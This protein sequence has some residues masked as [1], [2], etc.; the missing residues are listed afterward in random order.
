VVLNT[1]S[2]LINNVV[3]FEKDL[4]SIYRKAAGDAHFDKEYFTNLIDEKLKICKNLE[5]AYRDSVTDTLESTFF[6]SNFQLPSINVN[7]DLF[8]VK[9]ELERIEKDCIAC[10]E[11]IAEAIKNYNKIIYKYFEKLLQVHSSCYNK[12]L[13]IER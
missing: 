8:K 1:L 2:S 3:Q 4:T 9:T 10:Y 13:N 6:L 12:L 7:P 5:R 11:K